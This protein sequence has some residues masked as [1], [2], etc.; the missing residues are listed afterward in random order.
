[1]LARLDSNAPSS[2]SPYLTVGEAAD[3]LRSRRQR[4]YDLL[5]SGRLTRFKDGGRTLVLRVEVE[6]LVVP[7]R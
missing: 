1:V 6:A 5:S 3:L 2:T 4:V 7:G